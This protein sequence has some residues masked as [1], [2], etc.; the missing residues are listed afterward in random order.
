MRRFFVRKEA[1]EG[2]NIRI[3]GEEARHICRVLRLGPGQMINVFDGTGHEYEVEIL[4][5]GIDSVNG[6]I[7]GTVSAYREAPLPVTLVQALVKGDKMDYIIQKAVELGVSRIIPFQAERSVVRLPGDRAEGRVQRWN[8]VAREACKQCGRAV[9]P[10]VAEV[11]GFKA[12]LEL[13]RGQPGII[14]YENEQAERKGLKALLSEQRDS[15]M[16]QGVCIYIGPE[17]GFSYSEV[18]TARAYGLHKASLGPRIL[19]TETAGL[20]ALSII[21]YE[22]GDLGL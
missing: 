2:R 20:A 22:L 11:T 4:S 15:I 13:N 9:P 8:R 19:R 10:E 7:T 5:V 3:E 18:D 14:F 21:M 6:R 1:I 16:G 17:G 12:A